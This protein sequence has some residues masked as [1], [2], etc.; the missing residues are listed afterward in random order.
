MAYHASIIPIEERSSVV[1]LGVVERHPLRKVC[2]RQGWLSQVVQC[3]PQGTAC[4]HE[5]GRVLSLLL[6]QGQELFTQFMRRLQLGTHVI[7]IPES[8]Q[9][10]KKL[11]RIVQ[12]LT[13]LSSVGVG[14]A[15]FTSSI[16]LHGKQRGSQGDKQV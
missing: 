6:R 4:R 3:R 1:L 2:M 14:L 10:R 11:V 16:A 12:V 8:T 7:M 15:N 9:H 13:E 5:H